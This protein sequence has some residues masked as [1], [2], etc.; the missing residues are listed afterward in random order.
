MEDPKCATPSQPG[1]PCPTGEH[2]GGR[3]CQCCDHGYPVECVCYEF[4][5][6]ESEIRCSS[7][8]LEID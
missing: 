4:S 6:P 2:I 3:C 7:I 8:G 5:A 1:H